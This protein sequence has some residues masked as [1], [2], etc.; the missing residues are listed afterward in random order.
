[1]CTIRQ[2]SDLLKE[3]LNFED[4]TATPPLPPTF[5]IIELKALFFQGSVSLIQ[6]LPYQN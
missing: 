3:R 4:F 6:N 1:M 2:N 5:K